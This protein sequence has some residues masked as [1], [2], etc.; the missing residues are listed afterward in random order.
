MPTLL[1]QWLCN[2][3]GSGT[4]TTTVA[5]NSGNGHNLSVTWDTGT[6][7]QTTANGRGLHLTGA[8]RAVGSVDL[9][10][11]GPFN[12]VTVVAAVRDASGGGMQEVNVCGGGAEW[13]VGISVG[14]SYNVDVIGLS[15]NGWFS[16]APMEFVGSGSGFPILGFHVLFLELDTTGGGSGAVYVNNVSQSGSGSYDGSPVVFDSDNFFALGRYAADGAGVQGTVQYGEIWDC[17]DRLFTAQERL[18][19]YNN[20]LAD[21]DSPWLGGGGPGP[22]EF[23]SGP[24]AVSPTQTSVTGEATV[25]ES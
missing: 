8:G 22:L 24:S 12:R 23:T 10:S 11:I 25:D 15:R 13:N 3:A 5:D 4:G 16:N 14:K 9:S 2:D 7:W 21:T 6:G 1:G 19:C 20:L 18:D 17:D